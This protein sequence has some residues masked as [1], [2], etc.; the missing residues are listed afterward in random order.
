MNKFIRYY[1][2]PGAIFQSSIIAGGYGTGR[3]VMEY[4]TRYGAW[5][6]IVACL[7]AALVFTVVLSLTW[8]L[9]RLSKTYDYHSFTKVLLGPAWISYEALFITTLFLVQAVIAAAAGKVVSDLFSVGPWVGIV[10][11]LSVIVTLNYFG[12]ALVVAC[13]G[14]TS[15]MVT[16][17][18]V[19]FCVLAIAQ[20]PEAMASLFS[21]SDNSTIDEAMSSG[22]KFA[23]YNCLSVPV[24]LYAVSGQESRR[25]TV[26]AGLFG[27]VFAVIPAVLLHLSF[28]ANLPDLLDYALPT[29]WML[30][31]IDMQWVTTVYLLVLFATVAQSGV[32]VLQGLNERIDNSLSKLRGKGLSKL[33]HASIAA[34]VVLVSGLFA[35]VGVVALIAHGYRYIAIGLFAVYLLPL[36]TVGLYRILTTKE[37]AAE[38]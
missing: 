15:I 8:E 32:G 36:L 24:I 19:L 10:L 11:M 28:L 14:I 21:V 34:G 29:Y 37:A 22:A 3:E 25:Q 16:L 35:Q 17:V 27:G 2:V 30:K 7:I 4:I 33:S 20:Q 9:A 1:L 6:G 12:R 18:L 23:M 13:M 31:L 26:F 38:V 5:G